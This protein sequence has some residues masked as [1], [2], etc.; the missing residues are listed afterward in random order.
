M[1][2]QHHDR[3]V[4]GV[5]SAQYRVH[6]GMA[7]ALFLNARVHAERSQAQCGLLFDAG[8]GAHHMTDETALRVKGDQG[9]RRDPGVTCAER[10]HQAGLDRRPALRCAANA[11]ACTFR[12]VARSSVVS[13][14]INTGPR[15]PHQASGSTE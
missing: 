8:S 1:A 7:Y 10:I 3:F 11:A 12:V 9:Q 14:L 4:E 13:R 2:Q 5:G 6:Q 15:C